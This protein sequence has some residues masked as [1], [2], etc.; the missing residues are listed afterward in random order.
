M[1]ERIV[2]TYLTLVGSDVDVHNRVQNVLLNPKLQEFEWLAGSVKFG[3]WHQKLVCL[4]S[5][6]I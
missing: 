1:E 3:P 2:S 4:T 6:I 5:Q